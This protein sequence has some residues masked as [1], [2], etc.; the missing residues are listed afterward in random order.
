MPGKK[1][2]I[3][4]VIVGSCG[5][6]FC[7]LI[8]I[9]YDSLEQLGVEVSRTTNNFIGQSINVFV[10]STLFF[11]ESFFRQIQETGM[12]YIVFQLEAL[13]QNLGFF[14]NNTA[15]LKFLRGALQVW[16]YSET[17]VQFL[18]DRSITHARHIPI[19]YS[20]GLEKILHDQAKEIDVLFYGAMSPRRRKIMMELRGRTIK[21][22]YLFGVY[23]SERDITIGKSKIVINIHQFS[24]MQLEQL[25]IS[26][27]LN[28][29]CLVVSEISDSNL[30]GDGVVFSEYGELA[31]TCEMLLNPEQ[32]EA[33]KQIAELGYENLKSLPMVE[34]IKRAVDDLVSL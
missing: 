31:D 26:Y 25:R 30:Y 28:N 3:I 17:N 7:E 14:R 16:D 5:P 34:R 21:V 33:R 12:P 23:G 10:G 20:P 1:I 13:D 11:P 6:I 2:N 4:H 32:T 29:K 8:D 9:L 22:K 24:T 27:L 15:Y 19:G 18:S